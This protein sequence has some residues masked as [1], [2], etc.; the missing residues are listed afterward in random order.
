MKEDSEIVLMLNLEQQEKKIFW[1][2]VGE[3]FQPG[4]NE[5]FF[6]QQGFNSNKPAHLYAKLYN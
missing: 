2:A 1:F 4:K 6:T 3:F 5:C